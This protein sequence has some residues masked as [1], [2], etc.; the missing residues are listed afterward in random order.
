M[1][2]AVFITAVGLLAGS[3]A[4]AQ[5]APPPG[6]RW[7]GYQGDTILACKDGAG[8]WRRSGDDQIVGS[9]ALAPKPKPKPTLATQ[10]VAATV[11]PAIES[12]SPGNAAPAAAI[13]EA[14]A[15]EPVTAGFQPAAEEPAQKA[16]E[17]SPPAATPAAAPEPPW[18]RK[19]LS[20]IWNALLAMLRL[21]GLLH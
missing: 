14:T 10:K 5:D 20:G 16:A 12:D 15:A 18:W 17:T 8:H 1:I 3:A 13:A 6:C 21:F 11:L 9:Y 2:R 7:Q 19:A 4:L